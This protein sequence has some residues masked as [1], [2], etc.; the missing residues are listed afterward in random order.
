MGFEL[1]GKTLGIVG[2]GRIGLKVAEIAKGFGMRILAYDTVPN[3]PQ[4]QAIGFSYVS[5]DELLSRSDIV[6]LHVPYN[7]ETHYLINK[8][9]IGKF[10]PG[11]LLVNTARGEICDTEALLF[12]IQEKI[13]A[14]VA[15][16]VVEGERDLKEESQFFVE[17]DTMALDPER[18]KRL[19]E[20][21]ILMGRPEVFITPHIAFFTAE[22]E[23]EIIL[24]SIANI[25]SFLKD[26]TIP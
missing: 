3:A 24:T 14:G 2:T 18:I 12:G 7:T 13:L 4:A 19:L 16:D 21:H 15:L 23:H 26:Q 1:Y 10:K 11:A 8:D 6:T 25:V 17:R 5:L 22:A 9:N 20:D